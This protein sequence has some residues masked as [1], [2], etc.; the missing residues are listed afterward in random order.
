VRVCSGASRGGLGLRGCARLR[1]VRALRSDADAGWVAS[2]LRSDG[3]AGGVAS[4]LLSFGL[5]TDREHGAAGGVGVCCEG[6]G[7]PFA[8]DGPR[9]LL[10]CAF[11]LG[12]GPAS[13]DREQSA[14][15]EP[16]QPDDA[17]SPVGRPAARGCGLL[18]LEGLRYLPAALVSLPSEDAAAEPTGEGVSIRSSTDRG[19]PWGGRVR[20][21]RG[22]VR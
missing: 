13:I 14:I 10:G 21:V 6:A 8:G 15:V 1:D 20:R 19:D 9:P 16:A 4:S 11:P 5:H 17:L 12:G 18:G 22:R 7:C 3:E 2:A